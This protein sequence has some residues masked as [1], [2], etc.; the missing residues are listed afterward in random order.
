MMSEQTQQQDPSAGADKGVVTNPVETARQNL[1][2]VLSSN[3]GP[4]GRTM[5]AAV[6]ALICAHVAHIA[7][8]IGQ[9]GAPAASEKSA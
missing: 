9:V 4:I 5:A 7:A 1:E 6:D 2:E 3:H 8:V